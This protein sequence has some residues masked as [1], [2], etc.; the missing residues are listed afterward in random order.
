[1]MVYRIAASLHSNDLTG[2]GAKMYGG[3]WNSVGIPMLYCSEHRSL[4]LLELLVHTSGRYFS[5][6]LDLITI[7]IPD[8]I[9]P[10]PLGPLKLNW[11]KDPGYTQFIGDAFFR[12]NQNLLLRVPS[13]VVQQEFNYIINPK[14]SD[15]K[16]IKIADKSKFVP[17]ERLLVIK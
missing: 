6:P 10:A 12:S 1:M 9:A 15:F 2:T 14:H 4:S 17:D 11:E 5:E 3:R 8:N 13:A 16:K 7:K